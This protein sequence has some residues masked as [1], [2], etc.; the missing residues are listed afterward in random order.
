MIRE[1]PIANALTSAPNSVIYDSWARLYIKLTNAHTPM[2]AVSGGAD[3]D[4]VVHMCAEL[5]KK[6]KIKYVFFDTGL[7]AQ[8]TKA[9]LDYLED[10]YEIS[11]ERNKPKKTVPYCVRRYGVPFL[12]KRVSDHIERLQNHGFKFEDESFEVLYAR[13]PKCKSSL[14]WWCNEFGEG[15]HF[16]IEQNF[17]LK[18]FMVQNPPTFKIS[19]KCCWHVKKSMAHKKINEMEADLNITGLRKSEGGARATAYKSCFSPA[20]D[21]HVAEFRPIFWYENATKD[22]FKKQ[23]GIVNSDCYEAWGL[24][25]TGCMGC[26]FAKDVQAELEAVKLHE[27][28][29]YKALIAVFGESYEYTAK[30]KEFQSRT[31]KER[32]AEKKR[33]KEKKYDEAEEN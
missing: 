12:S 2:C 29:L 22:E 23:Y 5:D 16:N 3:S 13:Y 30:F 19:N 24:R 25:R 1:T 28:N 27:P 8:A 15:S 26:P 17:G 11:I 20:N 14:R 33:A 10:R 7:E 9:H 6:R 21:K 31:K 32:K 4:I 18:E